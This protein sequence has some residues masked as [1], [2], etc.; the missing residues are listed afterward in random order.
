MG[1]VSDS[2]EM[3]INRRADVSVGITGDGSCSL[4][5]FGMTFAILTMQEVEMRIREKEQ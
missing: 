3:A 4:L 2:T 5:G 1:N